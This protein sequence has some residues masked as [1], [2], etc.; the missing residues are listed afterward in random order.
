MDAADALARRPRHDADAGGQQV[1]AGQ[2]EVGVAAA[3]QP[4]KQFLDTLVDPFE[5]VLEPRPRLAVDLGDGAFQR[6]QRLDQV[7]VLRIEVFLALRFLL[8]F[9][10][11]RQV[12]RLQPG[13]TQVQ[14]LDFGLP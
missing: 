11:G 7:V 4:G 12:H 13:N 6:L 10:D 3:E 14:A 5:G 1:F 9:L 8:V 2:L